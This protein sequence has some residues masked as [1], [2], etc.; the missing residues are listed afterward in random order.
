MNFDEALIIGAVIHGLLYGL[1]IGTLSHCLRWLL[2]DDKGWSYRKNISW[3]ML[4]VT[5]VIFLLSTGSLAV[6]FKSV[7]VVEGIQLNNATV[8]AQSLPE[9]RSSTWCQ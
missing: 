2:Y 5:V 4:T 9:V 8:S 3:A 7:L 6:M 1:Y